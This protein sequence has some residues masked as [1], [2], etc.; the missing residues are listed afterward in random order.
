M[1]VRG[2]S[3]LGDPLAGCEGH[4]ERQ[5]GWLLRGGF[6]EAD[7]VGRR[8]FGL[9]TA[10]G[11]VTGTIW[12]TLLPHEAMPD[13]EGVGKDADDCSTGVTVTSSGT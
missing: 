6:Q 12:R 1:L 13:A 8:T 9:R 2:W 5:A 10:I 4:G 11:G 3:Y 7:A